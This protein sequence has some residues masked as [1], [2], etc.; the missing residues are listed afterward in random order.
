MTLGRMLLSSLSSPVASEK[1]RRKISAVPAVP[2]LSSASSCAPDTRAPGQQP[3]YISLEREKSAEQRC[4]VGNHP[5]QQQ[6]ERKVLIVRRHAATVHWLHSHTGGDVA[7]QSAITGGEMRFELNTL[8][9]A[10]DAF[11]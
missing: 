11:T 3:D 8:I 10:T 7:A 2:D 9:H 6:G 4:F 1:S 5:V